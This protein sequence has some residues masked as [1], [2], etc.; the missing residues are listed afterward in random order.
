VGRRHS[1]GAEGPSRCAS[2]S[3]TGRQVTLV[4]SAGPINRYVARHCKPAYVIPG[5]HRRNQRGGSA[6]HS[7][8]VCPLVAVGTFDAFHEVEQHS[9]WDVVAECHQGALARRHQ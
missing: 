1:A 8:G 9:A 2:V 4:V 7:A 3:V 6:D 5:A